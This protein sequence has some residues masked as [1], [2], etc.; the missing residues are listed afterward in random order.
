M[1]RISTLQS[2][3]A[4]CVDYLKN[5]WIL[6]KLKKRALFVLAIYYAAKVAKKSLLELTKHL[7]LSSFTNMISK[8]DVDDLKI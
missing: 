8:L 6:S 7:K 1:A 2:A 4:H 5:V 3:L